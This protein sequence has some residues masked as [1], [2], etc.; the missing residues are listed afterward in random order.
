MSY[1]TDWEE[2]RVRVMERQIDKL[3]EHSKKIDKLL[4]ILIDHFPNDSF[5]QERLKLLK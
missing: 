3:T 5:V 2:N 4:A 1:K